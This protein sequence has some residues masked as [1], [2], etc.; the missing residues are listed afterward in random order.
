MSTILQCPL[1]VNDLNDRF[2]V[3]DW[4]ADQGDDATA[5]ALRGFTSCDNQCYG[6]GPWDWL[7]VW[8]NGFAPQW[9]TLTLHVLEKAMA[10]N[11]PRL[12]QGATT[13][14]PPLQCVKDWPCEA[15]DIIGSCGRWQHGWR[16]VGEV[17][18][19]FARACYD[20]DQRLGEPAMCRHF[21]NWWD[22]SRRSVVFG[23]MLAEVRWELKRR[24]K[25]GRT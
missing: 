7:N 11:S 3:A 4:Y 17:E 20:A 15:A 10:T 18:E 13:S 19:G 14:P 16:A 1:E 8:R 23:I 5:M 6:S 21:L 22:D 24:S 25:K 2:I 12:L 9:T